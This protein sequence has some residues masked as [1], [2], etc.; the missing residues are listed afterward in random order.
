MY[1]RKSLPVRQRNTCLKLISLLFLAFLTSPANAEDLYDKALTEYRSG[2]FDRAI[3]ALESNKQKRSGD[4]NL[5]GWAYLRSGRPDEA[6]KSF[7]GSLEKDPGALNS[8]CGLGYSYFRKGLLP[9]AL[10]NFNRSKPEASRDADC[11]LGKGLVLEGMGEAQ[12]AREAFA[13]VL[14]I[15]KENPRARQRLEAAGEVVAEEGARERIEF[16]ARGNYFWIGKQGETPSPVYLKGVNLGF[17]T[18]GKF[19]T[20]FPEEERFYLEWFDSIG[21]M[22][23][24]VIRVYTLLP[25][26][27]YSALKKF[28]KGRPFDQKLFLIQGIWAELPPDHD[29]RAAHYLEEVKKEI[30]NAV[31]IIHGRAKIE[32][33]F[34]HAHGIY[35]ND[36][37]DYV[38]GFIFGREW[39]PPDVVAYNRIGKDT[40]FTGK[41]LAIEN[42]TPMEAW[43]TWMLDHL[44]GY[45]LEE[46]KVSRPVAFMNWPP[47]D[48][49][50]HP[51]EATLEEEV[52]LRR[53][54]GEYLPDRDFSK[55][56]DED[57]ASLDE[58]KI[59]VL[60]KAF[61]GGIFS[62][63]HVYPYYPDF[64]RNDKKYSE[65]SPAGVSPYY[66]NYL[67]ELKSRYRNMPLLISEYGVPTSRGVARFHPAGLD[68]GGHNEEEQARI[69]KEL[70]LSIKEA[71][72]AG[73][74]VFSWIDEWFK[75]NWMTRASE[76]NDQLWYNAQDPEEAYGVV[77]AAPT[78]GGKLQGEA[79]SWKGSALVYSKDSSPLTPMNDGANPGRT[80]KRLFADSDAGYLYLRM[81][82]GGEIDWSRAAYIIAIDLYSDDEGDHLLP[83]STGYRSPVGFEYAILLHG[84]R[85]RV[86]VDDKLAR[87]VFDASL[88]KLPGLTGYKENPVFGSVYNE[89]GLFSDIIVTHRRRFGRDGEIYPETFYNASALRQGSIKEDSLADFYYSKEHGTIEIRLP[90]GLL[91]VADPSALRFIYSSDRRVTTKGIRLM[92]VSY[93]PRSLDDSN[94]ANLSGGAFIT[95]AI[96]QNGLISYTW[97]GWSQPE[98]G[99]HLKKAYHALQKEFA[100]LMPPEADINLPPGFEFRPVITNHYSSVEEFKKTYDRGLEGAQGK[101]GPYALALASLVKGFAGNETFYILDAGYLFAISAATAGTSREKELAGLGAGYTDAIISGVHKKSA[102]DAR[103]EPVKI[104]RVKAP[105]DFT[106]IILGRSAIMLKKGALVKTQVERVSRDWLSAYNI[107]TP[108]W[109]IDTEE[110]VP[111]HEGA[112]IKEIVKYAGARIEP[113]WGTVVKKI[114]G[115]WYAPDAGGKFRFSVSG[116]K[117]LN[118]PSNL[119]ADEGTAVINDT[120]GISAIAWDSLGADLAV[121]CG[122]YYGKAEAA[123][124]LASNGV[125]VYMPTDRF[126][127]ML[128]GARTK[129]AIIGS[130]PVKKRGEGAVIGDQPVTIDAKEPIVVTAS[131]GRYPLQYY[132][133]PERYFKALAE[134]SGKPMNVLPVEVKEYGGAGVA[135]AEA[136]RVGA[137]VVGIRA[138]VKAEH[139]AVASWLKEDPSRRAILFHTAAYEEGYRLFF[140]FPGQ[141]SFGDISP[142]FH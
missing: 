28:N 87:I 138:A 55:A 84:D 128:I 16:F 42:A 63:Y 53:K 24:N 134:Y 49:L 7:M 68:H 76:E 113:V 94:A 11:L 117:V 69:L 6:V 130:A 66:F 122:D 133:T 78:H 126:A 40:A 3:E 85:S 82:V 41:R 57:A 80:I 4:F 99:T 119:V 81:D 124:Y 17:G 74:I 106:S 139:D 37:S 112:R 31:G 30:E 92:A 71:G 96:P 93:K 116:D 21:R 108:P 72:S 110:I 77:A 131:S 70:T 121:G 2:R 35:R 52:A 51:S 142:E 61:R 48:P 22:N 135:I 25:P 32:K 101:T 125:N 20:E 46:F 5:L 141:T 75:S 59:Q 50:Y 79:G 44:V 18:P 9:Q 67:K 73:G 26:Q 19:P 129:A 98:Y 140:E 43:L 107:K 29:F 90:W 136:R 127:N 118:Y 47:L 109:E 88:K 14:S 102:K 91:G 132:D 38:M 8:Y 103:L 36:V 89:N 60:D 56:F 33:R 27:F 114:D 62:S 64:L 105:R 86:V 97:K 137:K 83:F 45:E 120:H 23:A 12:K 13:A 39:E 58:T 34:G 123:Y 1:V 115:V 54:A 95:D 104:E 65:A 15:D 111:W 100:G 10:E